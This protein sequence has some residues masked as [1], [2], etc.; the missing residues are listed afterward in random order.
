MQKTRHMSEIDEYLWWASDV[1]NTKK[2]PHEALK[3]SNLIRT[4][5]LDLSRDQPIRL[6]SRDDSFRSSVH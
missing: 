3:I 1:H 2:L 6:S 5:H 4:L